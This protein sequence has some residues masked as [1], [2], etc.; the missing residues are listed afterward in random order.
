MKAILITIFN[1]R[2]ENIK[3]WHARTFPKATLATQILK[4][5]EELKEAKTA[6]EKKF[7][8]EVADIF[9]V[10]AGLKRWS[11]LIAEFFIDKFLTQASTETILLM[12]EEIEKKMK[13][14]KKRRWN[15]KNGYYRHE[16]KR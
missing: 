2:L 4:L 10:C 1:E 12:L 16:V 6:P 5:E 9:I 7:A 14:N 11:S 15:E 8:Q 3:K 13:I